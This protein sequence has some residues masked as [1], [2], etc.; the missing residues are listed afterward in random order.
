MFVGLNSLLCYITRIEP[1]RRNHCQFRAHRTR[2]TLPLGCT[3]ICKSPQRLS[4][5]MWKALHCVPG[6]ESGCKGTAAGRIGPV[7]TSDSQRLAHDPCVAGA[8][9]QQSEAP[10]TVVVHSLGSAISLRCRAFLERA[11]ESMAIEAHGPWS[12]A[13]DLAN[14]PVLLRTCAAKSMFGSP[15]VRDLKI[16]LSAPHRSPSNAITQPT[17]IITNLLAAPRS[18]QRSARRSP[19][20]SMMWRNSRSMRMSVAPFTAAFAAFITW[21]RLRPIHCNCM[22]TGASASQPIVNMPFQADMTARLC[23]GSTL[24]R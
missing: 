1:C 16:G 15:D 2:M 18:D 21:C 4:R 13:T 23:L 17:S 3:I 12:A 20:I 11:R 24:P 22:R 8:V 5:S 14:L 7:A 10:M 19:C 6:L 9:H